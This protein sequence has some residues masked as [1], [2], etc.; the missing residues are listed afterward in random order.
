M[1]WLVSA[2]LV[3][4][5]VIHLLP[6]PGILGADWLARLYGVAITD[7][8]MTIMMRHRALLFGVLGLLM[9][10]ASA[11]PEWQAPAVIA[12][13]VSAAGFILLAWQVGGYSPAIARV[14]TADIVAVAALLVSGVGLV[15]R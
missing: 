4:A 1:N 2:G 9:L 8:D 5:A 11:K 15:L 3:V 14:V 6:V 7:P 10:A 13:L 12:G